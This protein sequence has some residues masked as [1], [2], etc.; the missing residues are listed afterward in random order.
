MKSKNYTKDRTFWFVADFETTTTNTDYWDANND[1]RVILANSVNWAG[2]KTYTFCSIDDWFNFHFRLGFSQT[3]YFHNLAYDG[4]YIIKYLSQ[5]TKFKASLNEGENFTYRVFMNGTRIY[6]IH[7]FYR[8]KV[9]GKVKDIN[10]IIRCSYTLLNCSVEALGKSVGLDKHNDDDYLTITDSNGR[11]REF[12]DQEPRN[13]L[14]DWFKDERSK[15]FYEY[16]LNDCEIVRRALINFEE[17]IGNLDVVIDYNQNNKSSFNIFHNLTAASLTKRI[18]G[19]YVNLYCKENK[20]NEKEFKPLIISHETYEA[21]SPWFMGGYSQINDKYINNA[22]HVSISKM[23]DV[24]SAY[25]YQM[26]FPLPFGEMLHDEPNGKE[27]VDYYR[28]L[29]LKIKR[30]KIKDS[31][32][33]TP[34]LINWRKRLNVSPYSDERYVREL[35]DFDAYYLSFEWEMLKN[36]YDFEVLE[37]NELYMLAAPYLSHY[38]KD[39]YKQKNYYSSIKSE[40]LKQSAKILLNAGYG[41]LAIR[42]KFDANLVLEKDWWVAQGLEDIERHD[43]FNLCIRN[44]DKC[45]CFK[46]INENYGKVLRVVCEDLEECTKSTNKAAAAVITARE[47]VYLWDFINKVGSKH[48]GLSDTDSILFIN[49]NHNE[50]EFVNSCCSSGLGAWELEKENIEYFGCY[51]AKKYWLLDKQENV[52]KFRFAGVTDKVSNMSHYLDY[53]KYDEEQIEVKNA[54]LS[55]VYTKSGIALIKKD[56]IIERG[57]I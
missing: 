23:V 42:E 10:I 53:Y 11:V 33:E 28:F 1:V 18:M 12:Y 20:L 45:F 16:C 17:M 50:S 46:N 13:E 14:Q 57:K 37:I 39:L 7:L 52:M 15:R 32:Y 51:G 19:Y 34:T 4:D 6:Y 31:H 30:A 26:T 54:V 38:A 56:K 24:S 9:D 2:D 40:G 55:K 22:Q 44:K 43:E 35:K 5:H 3:I 25:P 48:F 49:L 41:C 47:R 8:L 27:N 36:Y 21:V 29:H